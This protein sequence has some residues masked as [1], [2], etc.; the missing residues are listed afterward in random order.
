M[1]CRFAAG[2]PGCR[3]LLN[4]ERLA[5]SFRA[6]NLDLRAVSTRLRRWR[7]GEAA[8]RM[9]SDHIDDGLPANAILKYEANSAEGDPRI[10]IWVET[11]AKTSIPSKTA[12]IAKAGS[13]L[14]RSIRTLIF[15]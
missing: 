7:R 2:V 5:S 8:H 1:E 13:N 14:G 4:V 11:P 10:G 12:I 6:T 3:G 15:S 9:L